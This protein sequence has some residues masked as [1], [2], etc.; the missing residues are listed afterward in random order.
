VN[1]R[2]GF[3]FS[4]GLRSI[5]RQDPD[6]IMLG[7]MRDL[8]TCQIAIRAA[9][10]GHL[11]FSTLHTN[12]APSA[13]TRLIDMGVESFLVSACIRGILAQRLVRRLCESCKKEKTVPRSYL[14]EAGLCSDTDV[15]SDEVMIY[16]PGKC[17]ECA[18]TGYAGRAGVFELM[19]ISETVRRLIMDRATD[20][21]IRDAAVKNGM[22]T[23]RRDGL[24]H[25]LNGVTSI[26][27]VLRVT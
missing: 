18:G 3:T 21:Q 16:E 26:E 2:I 27:E 8:D 13:I 9:L 15:V 11:V 4:S 12:D 25:V 23:L 1:E 14:V 7:E 6:I 17:R 5:L 24:R 20:S 19:T 10:T 22:L